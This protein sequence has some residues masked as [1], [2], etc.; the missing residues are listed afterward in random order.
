MIAMSDAPDVL[1]AAS[2]PPL[3]VLTTTATSEHSAGSFVPLRVSDPEHLDP[4]DGSDERA[5]ES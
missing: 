1:I 5:T 3:I 4:G 2:D